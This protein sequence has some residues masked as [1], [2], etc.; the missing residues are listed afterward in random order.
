M[1][2]SPKTNWLSSNVYYTTHDCPSVLLNLNYYSI[3]A[4]LFPFLLDKM[5]IFTMFENGI[6]IEVSNVLALT[7]S[8]QMFQNVVTATNSTSMP[9]TRHFMLASKYLMVLGE[10]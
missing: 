10:T 7:T 5:L 4:C 3:Y 6:S 9:K 8:I 1:R 2:A